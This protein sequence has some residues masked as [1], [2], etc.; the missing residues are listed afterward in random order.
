MV[1]MAR[2]WMAVVAAVVLLVVAVNVSTPGCSHRSHRS[3]QPKGV[4]LARNPHTATSPPF[5]TFLLAWG[6]ELFPYACPDEEVLEVQEKRPLEHSTFHQF[7]V[8]SML[9]APAPVE[10]AGRSMDLAAHM[11]RSRVRRAVQCAAVGQE[12]HGQSLT[13]SLPH[14]SSFMPA[15]E[16]GGA[17]VC[18]NTLSLIHSLWRHIAFSHVRAPSTCSHTFTADSPTLRTRVL[19][20][21]ACPHFLTVVMSQRHPLCW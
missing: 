19:P 21:H 2:P 5:P 12:L 1:S 13:A 9:N 16:H 3:F 14:A 17:C 7:L 4:S 6:R 8:F 10:R 15:R 20:P 11:A 18:G